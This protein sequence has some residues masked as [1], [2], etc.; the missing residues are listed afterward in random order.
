[1]LTHHFASLSQLDPLL[2]RFTTCTSVLA[3]ATRR[4]V[5]HW[6]DVWLDE[7]D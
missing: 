3:D 7:D 4:D 5:A 6:F 2:L 1:M